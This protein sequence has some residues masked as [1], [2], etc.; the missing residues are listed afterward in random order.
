LIVI[1]LDR[2]DSEE[3]FMLHYLGYVFFGL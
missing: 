1:L 2:A 3:N